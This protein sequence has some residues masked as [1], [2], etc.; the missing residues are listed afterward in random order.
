MFKMFI[1][2]H[3][4]TVYFYHMSLP[5]P[6][7]P[8]RCP[9]L[10]PSNFMVLSKIKKIQGPICVGQLFLNTGSARVWFTY[11]VSLVKENWFFPQQL[12]VVNSF[13]ARSGTWCLLALL[14]A[15]IVSDLN[16]Q[17]LGSMCI[18]PVVSWNAVSLKSFITSGSYS[19][20]SPLLYKSLSF[21]VGGVW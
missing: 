9:L 13:L 18:C 11:S 15:R 1:L 4:H 16:Y 19:R 7:T 12:S 17:S 20:P 2:W 21:E 5:F 14:C 6:P 3:L 10:Y 8:P